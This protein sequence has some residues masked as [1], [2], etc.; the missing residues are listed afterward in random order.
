M[1]LLLQQCVQLY[2]SIIREPSWS[3]LYSAR[4]QVLLQHNWGFSSS[5]C[6]TV[7]L[8]EFVTFWRIVVPLSS[9]VK[10]AKKVLQGEGS[11]ILQ[12]VG[13]RLLRDAASHPRG[14]ES[15]FTQ[16]AEIILSHA[17]YH[18]IK[19]QICPCQDSHGGEDVYKNNFKG[20]YDTY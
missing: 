8:G 9:G 12:S 16:A 18:I 20:E 11:T 14:L 15:S 4:F 2:L 13:N 7:L 5:G 6:D 10:Q 1:L 3:R 19:C 17:T